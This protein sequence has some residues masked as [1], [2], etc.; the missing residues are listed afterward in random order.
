MAISWGA[1]EYSGGN[2]MRV[3]IEV[4]WEAITAGEAAATATVKY[5]TEN[6]YSY[7]DP[8]ALNLSGAIDGSV[9]FTNNDGGAATLR[10]T[11]TYTYNYPSTS[12]GSSPGTRT[13]TASV[14]GAYNGVTPSKSVT[15]NIPARPIGAPAAPSSV[16]LARTSDTSTK[17]SWVNNASAG[18]PYETLTIQ[19]SVN[20]GA[21]ATVVS[22]AGSTTSYSAATAANQKLRFQVRANNDAG[23]SSFVLSSNYLWTSPAAPT[24]P[25]RTDIAGPG[26]QIVW[27]NTGMG[28]TEYVTEVIGYK[29]GVSVGVIGT[30]ATGGTSFNHLTSTPIPYTTSDRWKYTVRHKT[31]SGTAL[32]SA[33]TAATSETAGITSPPN[34]P[35]G[36]NPNG[37]ILDPT[38]VNVFAWTFNTTDSSDQQA[39]QILRRVQGSGTWTTETAVTSSAKTWN[40]P[41]NSYTNGQVVEWQVRARGA[42]TT[43][44]VSG[45]GYSDWSASATFT[46]FLTKLIVPRWNVG[47]GE[48]AVDVA[49][50]DW[51]ELGSAGA[52]A[53]QN[54][55]L[56]YGAPYPPPRFCRRGGVVY[57]QGMVK[58]GTLNSVIFTLPVGFRPDSQLLLSAIGGTFNTG[59]ASAG[60]AHTHA[61]SQQGGRL[62]I[63][64]NGDVL[65]VGAATNGW[66]SI[67]VSFP[68]DA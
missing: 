39:F 59:A 51:I 44:G 47:M 42:A 56:W 41:A 58:T 63:L 16:T 40:L 29:N 26:Q 67:F 18:N 32:Y 45:D 7:S 9:G 28:Y 14:S 17:V 68:A 31:S 61:I 10:A 22:P 66:Q 35:T 30:V 50:H 62:D 33:E 54:G 57:I 5:Y 27:A 21:M 46:M 3:G 2:G 20:G 43:G 37:A 13:F 55:W 8:Q 64:A 6:Q 52:P 38:E 65:Q 23:S 15:S 36:L 24:A 19:K 60:T 4:T 34:P 25:T 11:R 53:L 49:G 48:M 1:W 12:Y